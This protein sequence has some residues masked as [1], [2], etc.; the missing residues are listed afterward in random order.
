[1]SKEFWIAFIVA[2]LC[3]ILIHDLDK[4]LVVLETKMTVLVKE[5]EEK[6]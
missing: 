3:F 1:M 2:L 6:K 4:R 5:R